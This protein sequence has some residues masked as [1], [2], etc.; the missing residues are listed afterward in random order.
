MN[1]LT[2]VRIDKYLWSI[3]C[4]KSRTLATEACD[5]GKVKINGD[6]A[7]PSSPV[8]VG[9]DLHAKVNGNLKIYKVTAL[10]EKRVGAALVANYCIDSSPEPDKDL[11]FDGSKPQ[12]GIR[13]RGAGRPTKLDRR[14]IETFLDGE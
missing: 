2:K 10:L 12:F 11:F 8:K 9:D 4:F 6:N 13:E 14:D 1:E 7:K 5:S 3:R